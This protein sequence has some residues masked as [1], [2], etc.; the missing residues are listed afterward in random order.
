MR[1]DEFQKI[2]LNKD[3]FMTKSLALIA[4]LISTGLTQDLLAKD[5]LFKIRK[6][7]YNGNI[8]SG[9]LIAS[10]VIEDV[11]DNSKYLTLMKPRVVVYGAGVLGLDRVFEL[12]TSNGDTTKSSFCINLGYKYTEMLD[13]ETTYAPVAYFVDKDEVVIGKSSMGD[14]NKRAVYCSNILLPQT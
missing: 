9:A 7:T 4:L 8:Y 2:A 6:I 1:F 10:E 5:V 13:A 14:S 11:F 3:N 12:D